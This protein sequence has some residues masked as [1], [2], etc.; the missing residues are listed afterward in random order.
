[1][2]NTAEGSLCIGTSPCFVVDFF[3]FL[4]L[5]IYLTVSLISNSNSIIETVQL[6]ELVFSNSGFLTCEILSST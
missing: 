2:G 4:H 1:M 5:Y 6:D 3:F